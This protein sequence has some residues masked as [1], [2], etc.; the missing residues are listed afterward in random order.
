MVSDDTI[1]KIFGRKWN[2]V[3][4]K[5]LAYFTEKVCKIMQTLLLEN[6]EETADDTS[7]I[8]ESGT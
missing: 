8:G 3:S 4:H 6:R 1:L 2:K 5:Q 7:N